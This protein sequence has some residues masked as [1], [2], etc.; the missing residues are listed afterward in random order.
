MRRA[1]A[2]LTTIPSVVLTGLLLERGLRA[3]T[4]PDVVPPVE[5]VQF[6]VL[7]LCLAFVLIVYEVVA[8][9]SLE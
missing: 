3:I 1:D 7:G 2:V 8:A 4:L 5:W 9:P 6:T